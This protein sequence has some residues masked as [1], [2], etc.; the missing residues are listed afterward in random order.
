MK[1]LNE[2]TVTGRVGSDPELKKT[3]KGLSYSI[4]SLAITESEYD[5]QQETF[6]DRVTWITIFA[7][8]NCSDR[9]QKSV[10]KG[11]RLLVKGTLSTYKKD[12]Q[13]GQSITQTVFNCSDF[14]IMATPNK[15]GRSTQGKKEK[16]VETNRLSDEMKKIKEAVFSDPDLM[17]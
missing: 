1:D 17:F 2:F 12:I 9:I 10:K 3:S 5:S 15:E 4:L 7:F 8:G 13:G 6:N 11:S 14:S 16:T